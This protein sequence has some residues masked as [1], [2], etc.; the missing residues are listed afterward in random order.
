MKKILL[1][2]A[3][4]AMTAMT[5][6]SCDGGNGASLKDGV[7]SM[8]YNLGVA[9]SQGLKQ[10]M[11]MQLGVDSVYMD[12]FIKGLKEGALN[13]A[14]PKK[15]AYFKGVE[16]GK[17]IQEMS[18]GLSQEVYAGDTTKSVNTKNIL[19]GLIAGMKGTDKTDPE[20]AYNKFQAQLDPIRKANMEKKY[21]DNRVAGEKYLAENKKKEGVTTTASGL[22]YKVLV[23]GT[24]ALP[25]DTT[26]LQVNYEG[27]L[28]DG[29]VFDSS[30]ERKQPITIDMAHPGVI[31]GWIEVLKLMPAGSKWEVTIPQE[32]GY[33]ESDQGVIKPFSTLVFTIEVLK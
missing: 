6:V 18:K 2:A 10:V 33:G 16:M 17:R 19:A 25:T 31:P 1:M 30:Y 5:T 21:G 12:E 22:Q 24:G 23:E 4:V 29:T 26:K 32:L 15:D 14:D 28:I 11:T 9:Q 8:A 7:D 13:E 27:K 20:E 3:A